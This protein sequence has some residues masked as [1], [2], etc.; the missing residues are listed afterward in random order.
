MGCKLSR[1]L[2]YEIRDEHKYH[3]CG[4]CKHSRLD[5]D[6]PNTPCFQCLPSNLVAVDEDFCGW[7]PA[8]NN[9]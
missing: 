7:E 5:T 8:E 9:K 4:S 2:T 6:D 1:S 3:F